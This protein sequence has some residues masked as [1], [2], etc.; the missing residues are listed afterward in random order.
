MQEMIFIV[1]SE[2]LANILHEFQKIKHICKLSEQEKEE[3]D[4]GGEEL[5][6]RK[7]ARNKNLLYL[8]NT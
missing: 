4:K 3:K 7:M 1:K 8:P 5:L 6:L 2:V